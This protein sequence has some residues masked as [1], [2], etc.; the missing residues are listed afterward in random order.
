[1]LVKIHNSFIQNTKSF[2][3]EKSRRQGKFGKTA[4]N[5]KSIR[6][7][8]RAGQNQVSGEVNVP[9]WHATPGANF[10]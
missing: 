10:A 9:Y 6:E 5:N 2:Q 4:L 7:F 8:Q 1:M 3:D